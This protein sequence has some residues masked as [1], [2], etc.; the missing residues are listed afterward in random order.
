MSGMKCGSTWLA[1]L[2]DKH[3][4]IFVCPGQKIKTSPENGIESIDWS[5][6]SGETISLGRR[7]LKLESHYLDAY[8]QHNPNMKFVCLFRDPL[9]RTYSHYSHLVRKMHF[10]GQPI[11]PHSTGITRITYDYNIAI[12]DALKEDPL[13]KFIHKS[14]YYRSIEPYIKKFGIENF[15]FSSLEQASASPAYLSERVFEF[16]GVENK[17]IDAQNKIN[18][19]SWNKTGIIPRKKIEIIPPTEETIESLRVFLLPDVEQLEKAIQMQISKD[20]KSLA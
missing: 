11:Q 4:D 20:W 8:Y 17:K 19:R 1:N 12:K 14:L 16:L 3:P 18:E 7:N 10:I 15:L 13:P 5:A 6:Y 9:L 2:C